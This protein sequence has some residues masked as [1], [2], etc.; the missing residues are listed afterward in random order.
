MSFNLLAN[1]FDRG[2]RPQEA[3]GKSLVL[4]QQ[5]EQQMLGLDVRRLPNWL[6]SYRAK[7]ITRRAFSV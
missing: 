6:A 5:A 7:K 1:G 2:V 3:I 4:A